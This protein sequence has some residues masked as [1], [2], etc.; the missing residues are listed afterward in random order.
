MALLQQ[1]ATGAPVVVAFED[2]HW[3]DASTLRAVRAIDRALPDLPVALLVRLRPFPERSELASVID[4]LVS[5]GAAQLALG[6]LDDP[7]V[8][9]LAEA[10]AGG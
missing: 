7:A 8:T 2:L 9:A 1:L 4:E 6:A 10:V 5:H 3:A